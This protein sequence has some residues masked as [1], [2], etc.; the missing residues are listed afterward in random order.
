MEI[1]LWGN[2]PAT[3]ETSTQHMSGWGLQH[4]GSLW[5]G[6]RG[7][8]RKHLGNRENL[9]RLEQPKQGPGPQASRLMAGQYQ[10]PHSTPH[11]GALGVRGTQDHLILQVS[12][13]QVPLPLQ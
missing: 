5:G 11:P 9:L 8:S 6:D 2:E 3:K 4:R 10:H 7:F 12:S 13:G 1:A